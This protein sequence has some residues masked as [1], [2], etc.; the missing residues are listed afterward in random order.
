[1]FS[2]FHLRCF[3]HFC[4]LYKLMKNFHKH[5]NPV[6]YFAKSNKVFS[7]T[8]FSNKVFL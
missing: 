4:Q 8:I 2:F 7:E 3:S 1:M 5:L 6:S